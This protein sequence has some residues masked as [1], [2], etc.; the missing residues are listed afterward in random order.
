MSVPREQS[1]TEALF[2]SSISLI[3]LLMLL[4]LHQQADEIPFIAFTPKIHMWSKPFSEYGGKYT[5][6]AVLAV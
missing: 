2:S 4:L 5:E 1:A 6:I 3:A